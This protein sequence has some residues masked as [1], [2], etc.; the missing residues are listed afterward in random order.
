M[1]PLIQVTGFVWVLTVFLSSGCDAGTRPAT[2]AGRFYSSDPE[3]LSVTIE[4]ELGKAEEIDIKGKVIAL[5]SPHAGYT[6][7][8]DTM[9]AA[10]K[11]VEG[12]HYDLVVLFGTSHGY[13]G[14]G[15]LLSNAE[16]FETPLG[17]VPV[18][19]ETVRKLASLE[20]PFRI[21]PGAHAREH[22]IETQLPFLKQ[23]LR[24][25]FS[26]VPF[27]VRAHS[28]ETLERIGRGVALAVEGKNVLLVCSTDMTHYP[29]YE[30]ARRIDNEALEALPA[31]DPL[32]ARGTIDRL[33]LERVDGLSCIFC[34]KDALLAMV[35]AA[36]YLGAD[37]ARILRYRNSGDVS[38]GDKNRV[39]GYGAVAYYD[40]DDHDA[41]I[42]AWDQLVRDPRTRIR[43]PDRALDSEQKR[44]LLQIARRSLEAA[45]GG[46]DYVPPEPDDPMLTEQRGAFVTLTMAGNLRGCLGWFEADRPLYRVV[47][48]RARAS[49]LED[50]RFRSD[51]LTAED[52]PRIHIEISALTVRKPVSDL[53]EVEVGRHGLYISNG[54]RGGTLLPQVASECGWDRE[55]FLTHTCSKAGL[56]PDM[57]R[58]GAKIS[59]YGADVFGE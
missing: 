22:S 31:V 19:V 51:R 42:P 1:R 57:W 25:D 13:R 30:E 32:E 33:E 28:P 56:A 16:A 5:L 23:T 37:R 4:G 52:L 21:E 3:Q 11:Q 59:I 12:K 46:E 7:C 48:D 50:P 24:G 44:T 47:A 58:R 9:A 20:E 27:V 2:V 55:T 6:Y 10:Y 43:P 40:A 26:I 14:T 29:P 17:P 39:V 36:R 34:G 18:D 54:L 8:A 45:L 35:H 41:T 53:G 38:A 49:A 15:A